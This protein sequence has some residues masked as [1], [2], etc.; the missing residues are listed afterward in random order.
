M[1]RDRFSI[2][3]IDASSGGNGNISP[4]VEDQVA[5]SGN[6]SNGISLKGFNL[7]GRRFSKKTSEDRKMSLAQLTK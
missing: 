1:D 4:I 2:S 7:L 3:K 5:D 6:N